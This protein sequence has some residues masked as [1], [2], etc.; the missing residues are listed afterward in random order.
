MDVG[1]SAQ[2]DAEPVEGVGKR[3]DQSLARERRV[4]VGGAKESR[5]VRA[6]KLSQRG[7]LRA[8]Q[9]GIGDGRVDIL[10]RLEEG[11]SLARQ[12]LE[13]DG[14]ELGIGGGIARPTQRRQ[15]SWARSSAVR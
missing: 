1:L 13:V 4:E 2:V 12:L 14:A 6:A 15:S 7:Q 10:G 11:R 3:G 9:L 5:Q 8:S